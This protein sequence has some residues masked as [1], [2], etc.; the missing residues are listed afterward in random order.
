MLVESLLR[1]PWAIEQ[2]YLPI[3]SRVLTRLERGEPMSAS[4][5]EAVE[6]GKE[7][8]AARRQSPGGAAQGYAG[9]V[10]IIGVYGVLTQ[11]G[12]FD[13]VSMPTTSSARLAGAI[14]QAAADP[15]ISSVVL[16]VDS[17]GGQIF[18]IEELGN[19]VFEAR[20]AKPIAAV[21]NSL[22]AS[23]AYWVA[24]QASEFFAAPGAEVGSVGVYTM[25]VDYSEALKREGVAVSYISAG[26][27]KVEGNPHAPLDDAARAAVQDTINVY[28]AG[29]VRAVARGRGTT[30]KAVREG[31]GEG[32]LLLGDK[33]KAENM[34]DGT[35]T[36]AE[37][38]GRMAAKARRGGSAI[39]TPRL[40]AAQ[41][42]VLVS[43]LEAEL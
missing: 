40:N 28:Y 31:M 11:R 16:D 14:R 21:A 42:E 37:V 38:V 8:W 43:E 39:S 36:L 26:R 17:P 9:D 24:S 35:A 4:D 27:Y 33:A 10:A 23:A 22:A 3:V 41:R 19:A 29:F 13:D 5:R 7:R 2:S 1:Q 18:G 25:H 6:A 15:S 20:A 12:G 32:R 34:I 30:L